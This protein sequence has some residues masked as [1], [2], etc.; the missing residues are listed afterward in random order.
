VGLVPVIAGVGSLVAGS[1]VERHG[2]R[3]VLRV[4]GPVV[5]VSLVVIGAAPD[6]PVLMVGLVAI[7]FGL[8]AVDAAMNIAGVRV[9]D[10]AGRSLVAGF[11]ATW[12]FAGFV[13]G[14]CPVTRPSRC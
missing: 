8:G 2:S 7:G 12:S 3:A 4:M 13:G 5:P 6:V 9:Q 10:D 14:C 1:L 11:Y